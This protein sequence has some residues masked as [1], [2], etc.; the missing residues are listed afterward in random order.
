MSKPIDALRRFAAGSDDALAGLT[1]DEELS[2]ELASDAELYE[3]LDDAF[4]ERRVH[5]T[6][7]A[8]LLLSDAYLVARGGQSAVSVLAAH[9]EALPD[10]VVFEQIALLLTMEPHLR[11]ARE[12]LQIH[13][14]RDGAPELRARRMMIGAVAYKGCFEAAKAKELIAAARALSPEGVAAAPP[15][16]GMHLRSLL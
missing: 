8:A 6:S 7:D 2:S 3:S 10:D 5:V 9:V 14:A 12:A 1:R 15:W 4:R 16:V 11:D 13:L